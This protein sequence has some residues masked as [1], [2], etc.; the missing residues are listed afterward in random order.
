MK[1]SVEEISAIVKDE[2]IAAGYK[3]NETLRE[4]VERYARLSVQQDYDSRA[5]VRAE[6]RGYISGEQNFKGYWYPLKYVSGYNLD[7]ADLIAKA[8]EGGADIEDDA[9]IAVWIENR[10]AEVVAIEDFCDWVFMTT[11]GELYC[12]DD[13]EQDIAAVEGCFK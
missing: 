11:G 7:R 9:R 5:E 2:Y 4:N 8:R 3:W 12:P 13:T 1:F 6:I 10:E